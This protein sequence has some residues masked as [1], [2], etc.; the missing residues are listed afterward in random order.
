M[1]PSSPEH[2]NIRDVCSHT[3]ARYKQALR[4]NRLHRKIRFYG[5]FS[6]VPRYN[7]SEVQVSSI[8]VGM[9]SHVCIAGLKWLQDYHIVVRVWLE[10]IRE[11]DRAITYTTQDMSKQNKLRE[12]MNESTEFST[13]KFA[14]YKNIN[15]WISHQILSISWLI[16]Y[17]FLGTR[18]VYPLESW[19]DW[20]DLNNN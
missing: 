14:I 2:D 3:I 11:W 16:F 18:Y 19:G 5:Y 7:T 12:R 13:H 4:V 20:P 15:E 17:L 9:L 8:M 1:A 6:N 10:Q